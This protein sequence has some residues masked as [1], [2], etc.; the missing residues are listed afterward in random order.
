MHEFFYD[1]SSSLAYD[2]LGLQL[3]LLI[4]K[5]VHNNFSRIMHKH[6]L[7]QPTIMMVLA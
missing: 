7:G 1:I 2:A 3:V 6:D 4:L 5:V